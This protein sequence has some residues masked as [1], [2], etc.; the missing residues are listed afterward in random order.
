MD[1]ALEKL[2]RVSSDGTFFI[3]SL[4]VTKNQRAKPTFLPKVG[5]MYDV[6]QTAVSECL[7]LSG[8]MLK[9]SLKA[10][11]AVPDGRHD[12]GPVGYWHVISS[13]CK[14]GFTALS[15]CAPFSVT[16]HLKIAC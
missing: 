8:L 15:R 3:G 1:E 9:T 12:P 4:Q 5:P 13:V 6:L 2:L 16:E 11:I 14:I 10:V 7:H